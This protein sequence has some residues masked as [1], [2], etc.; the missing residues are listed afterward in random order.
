MYKN[1]D[2]VGEALKRA[3]DD[4]IVTRDEIYLVTKI[5]GDEK[6]DVEGAL[7]K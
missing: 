1:A 6:H 2:K 3:I 4:K 5:W 7:N